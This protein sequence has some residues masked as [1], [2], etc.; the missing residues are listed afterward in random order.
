VIENA[1]DLVTKDKAIKFKR[2]HQKDHLSAAL[3]T[4]EY[5]GRTQ[6]IS[7]I[8]SLKEGFVEDIHMYKKC[9]RHN[10]DTKSAYNNEEKFATQFFI[11]MRKHLD[12]II[13]HVSVPQVNLDVGNGFTLSSAGS[14][15]NDQ[16]YL[17]K[18]S[19]MPSLAHYSMS[20]V[21]R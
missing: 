17:W 19:R 21:G 5:L 3:E 15:P 4:E 2:Q 7:S 10:K 6:A 9:G 11:C 12:I 8:A 20:K 1:K 14:T 16:K 18:T 13:S